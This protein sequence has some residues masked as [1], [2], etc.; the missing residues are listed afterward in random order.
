MHQEALLIDVFNAFHY[1]RVA[2]GIH[3]GGQTVQ[4]IDLSFKQH[5]C[6]EMPQNVS[7]DY[8]RLAFVSIPNHLLKFLFKMVLVGP[9][10]TKEEQ[11]PLER[12]FLLHPCPFFQFYQGQRFRMVVGRLPEEIDLL[13]DEL[14]MRVLKVVRYLVICH[15]IPQILLPLVISHYLVILFQIKSASLQDLLHHNIDL[16]SQLHL[17]N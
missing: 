15:P 10:T 14:F 7:R 3:I 11:L 4:D 5:R 9:E 17:I 1:L 16:R 13:V 12:Q 6:I 8:Y 2:L